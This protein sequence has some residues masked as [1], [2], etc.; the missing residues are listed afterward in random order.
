MLNLNDE[1]RLRNI[2]KEWSKAYDECQDTW[3]DNV[4]HNFYKKFE[5]NQ[6]ERNIEELLAKTDK[7]YSQMEHYL[8]KIK[9]I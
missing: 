5:N 2:L 1:A 7:I 3:D 4:G 9:S 8:D 6:T